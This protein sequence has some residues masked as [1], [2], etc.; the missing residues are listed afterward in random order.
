MLKDEELEYGYLYVS[1]G[2]ENA[3]NM[4]NNG[5]G[6]SSMASNGMSSNTMMNSSN[7]V[8]T[9]NSNNRMGMFN[10]SGNNSNITLN[11]A[12]QLSNKIATYI[13]EKFEEYS[14]EAI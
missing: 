9:A 12:Q 14:G 11:H 6:N 7:F 4:A 8:N 2:I 10:S 1:G 5:N 3:A 13:K